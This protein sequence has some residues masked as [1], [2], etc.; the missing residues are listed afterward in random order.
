M[1]IVQFPVGRLRGVTERAALR[2]G[3]AGVVPLRPLHV[4][5]KA[6]APESASCAGC[7]G[8]LEFVPVVRGLDTYCSVECSLGHGGDRP[9]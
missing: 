3:T 6:D 2:H 4:V 8:P 5:T 9:A 7:A 1:G